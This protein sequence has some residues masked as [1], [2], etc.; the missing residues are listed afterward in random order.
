M[1]HPWNTVIED[2][3]Q[4]KHFLANVLLLF[5]ILAV[6]MEGGSR[7]ILSI[8]SLRQR[9]F[10]FDNSSYRLQWVARH[11]HHMEWAWA[12]PFSIYNSTRGWAVKPGIRN[13]RVADGMLL[14][15]NSRGV[16]G[17]AE[18]PY[19]RI[20][21]KLRIVTLGDS[22]TF[23]S[24]VNDEETFSRHLE[25]S[26]PDTEVL[27]L[28]VQGYGHDQMLL[29]LK[30]EGVK[31]RPDIVIVGFAYLDIY[32]NTLRFFAYAK[33]EFNLV[34]GNLVLT[35][36]PVPTPDRVLATEPYRPKSLDLLLILKDKLRWLLG[37]NERDARDVTKALLDEIIATSRSVRA[38]P[39]F[40][41]L[42]VYEEIESHAKG[43]S[44]PLI[45]KSIP[46]ADRE[47]YL[48]GICQEEHIPCLFLRSR[49][50][51]EVKRGVDLHP[52]GHWNATAHSLAAQ[53]MQNFLIAQG[54]IQ[55]QPAGNLAT[56][57]RK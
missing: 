9:V 10:S 8:G 35:N 32:R 57:Y 45:V 27:N 39:V 15:T 16:R 20:P 38:T 34:S 43:Q 52:Q 12:G 22:F 36:V 55:N 41:Y 50:D 42:P 18:Y 4:G 24:E 11:P 6:F 53:E 23:G 25:V 31:Y 51:A 14:T 1:T 48:H 28:G 37:K 30:D 56:R 3:P 19:E 13:M 29:Y 26:L 54:L 17:T 47:R 7:L 46:F 33:P 5:V 44:Y 21:G 2:K 49:F 40:V